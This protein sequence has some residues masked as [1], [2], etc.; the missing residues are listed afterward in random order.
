MR[1][2]FYMCQSEVTVEQF[3]QFRGEYNGFEEYKPYAGAISW[4]DAVAFCEWLSRK[5]GLPYRLPTEAEWEYACRAGTETAFW[6]GD[7]YMPR[8]LVNRWGLRNMHT[9]V[10]E[11][12]LDWHG[13]YTQQPQV[14][15]VGPERGCVRVARGGGLN[16]KQWDDAYYRRSA[17]R[18]GVAPTFAAPGP[19]LAGGQERR[20]IYRRD[21]D[22]PSRHPIGFRVVLAAMPDTK[23]TKFEPPALMRCVKQKAVMPRQGPKQDRPYYKVRR[24]FP[25]GL[26]LANVG[27]KIGIEPGVHPR[28]H[29]SALAALP[30][31]DMLVFYYN[32][33]ASADERDP[34]L[35]IVG[36]RRRHG[37][38]QWDNPSPWP[39]FFDANDEAPIIWN[40]NGT[41]WL[42]WGCPRIR[43]GYPFQWTT[44]T[45]NGAS[46]SPVRFPVFESIIGPYCCQ[47]INSAFRGPDGTV[48][49]AVDGKMATSIL[50]ATGNEG[51]SWFDTGGRTLG[52]HSTFVLLD[53]N[54]TILCYGGKNVHIDGFMPKNISTDWGRSWQVSKSPFSRLGGGQRASLIKLVSGRLF[55]VTDLR[56]GGNASEPLL[57]ADQLP[58]GYTDSG[59]YVGL[60]DD[61]GQSWRVKKLSDGGLLLN[62]GEITDVGSVGYVTSCQS[63]DGLIHLVTTSELH[64]TLNE[65]W[66]LKGGYSIP[67]TDSVEIIPNSLEEYCEKYPDG[68]P[69]VTWSAGV[70]TDG[71]Y[72][73][74][75]R[76]TWYYENGQKQWQVVYRG[77]RK[78]GAETYWSD[79]GTKRWTCMHNKDGTS[80]WTLLDSD[81]KVK[82]ESAWRG[83]KL[84]W[85]KLTGSRPLE[86]A[87][88]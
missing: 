16:Y 69:K 2:L 77:G 29:N 78:V 76:E 56:S 57:P 13:L 23:P 39:D 49:V 45:D 43:R 53:D 88:K 11:W 72:L 4:H 63:A 48:Y 82:A 75:G 58:D 21:V 26:D 87:I 81:G 79:D 52:R 42:F 44:S 5:E 32:R 24:L 62:D 85:Y 60:S 61:Q 54:K 1:K 55:F 67:N 25:Y 28:H 66:I 47:P 37:T 30:N 50:Y 65:A 10:A 7:G 31:G 22:M 83:K 27:W 3:Q 46:W 19:R 40:D 9:A 15:P 14:D 34:D 51:R 74:N 18:I 80:V 35:S 68:K 38:E 84:L 73:L 41:L 33:P 12:C 70:G 8:S 20:H 36:I 59:G 86:K 6:Y 71:R 17:N 64:I